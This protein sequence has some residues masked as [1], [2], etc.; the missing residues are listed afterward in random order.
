MAIDTRD[1]RAAAMAAGIPWMIITPI[2]DGSIDSEDRAIIAH[3]YPGIAAGEPV[4]GETMY[5]MMRMI[6]MVAYLCAL[7]CRRILPQQE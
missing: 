7:H 5:G 6:R 2:A 1:R 4:G 3:T